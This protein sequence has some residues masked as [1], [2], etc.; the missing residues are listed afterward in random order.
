MIGVYSRVFQS[1][2]RGLVDLPYLYGCIGERLKVK[3]TIYYDL[4]FACTPDNHAV[5]A[6]DISL[7]KRIYNDDLVYFEDNAFLNNCQV[8]DIFLFHHASIADETHTLLEII[9][10]GLGRFDATFTNGALGDTP[11]EYVSNITPLKSLIYQFGLGISGYD[12]NVDGSLQQFILNSSSQLSGLSTNLLPGTGNKDWQIF[13]VNTT[14]TGNG[15]VPSAA[16]QSIIIEHSFVVGPLFKAGYYDTYLDQI[17]PDFFE[18]VNTIQYS[19]LVDYNKSAIITA[20]VN[21]EQFDDIGRFSWFNTK[22][23]GSASDYYMNSL[24]LTKLSDASIINQLEYERVQVTFTLKSISGSFDSAN[25]ALLFGFNFLPDSEDD[26]INTGRYQDDNFVLDTQLFHPDNTVVNGNWSG[27]VVR[28]VIESVKG[29]VVDANTVNVTVIINPGTERLSIL[30]QD[31]NPA[32]AIWCIVEDTSL[33]VEISDKSNILVQVNEFY[34]QLITTNLLSNNTLFIEHPYD[35]LQYAQED[36]T[37]FPVDDVVANNL[38]TIDYA[39]LEDDNI[40]LKSVTPQIVLTHAIEADIVLDSY[41]IAL[42]NYPLVGSMPAIQDIKF[43]ANRPYKI[44]N[45]IRKTITFYRNYSLD[46]GTVKAFLLSFPFM[47]RWEYWIKVIGFQNIP[48]DLFDNTVPFGGAN[49][50]WNRLVNVSDWTLK[51]RSV[52]EII[53]NGQIFQ[54]TFDKEL[55]STGFN[56]N[57]DWSDC[58]IR[59]FDLITD[60]QI[61]VGSKNYVYGSKNTLIQCDFT[62]SSGIVPDMDGVWIVMWLEPFEG[63]GI[64][65]ILNI[66]SGRDVIDISCW[67]GIDSNPKRVNITKIGST[68]TGQAIIDSSKLPPGQKVIVYARIYEYESGNPLDGRITNDD[69][70]RM[71]LDGQIRLVN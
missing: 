27:D 71:T 44:E 19:S 41:F 49:E 66:D 5:F 25:T 56:S 18:S 9:S 2:T 12:S 24:V 48:T 21:E 7:S 29:V 46:S 54:Q 60:D 31:E 30:Q 70:L 61:I 15:A 58:E 52:F 35:T 40:L 14:I 28:Q 42:A 10:G 43:Q 22:F 62:K 6:P 3:T 59:S 67:K 36:L 8:G 26:Y 23:D 20:G 16:D 4:I 57:T 55:T 65:A 68:F 13:L 1:Q 34:V 39:G 37:M 51:F 45:G 32:Y 64:S 17:A 53:Q 63:G 11:G 69:I 33:P 47:N 38:I 50:L